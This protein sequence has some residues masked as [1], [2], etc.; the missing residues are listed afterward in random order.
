MV[1][2]TSSGHRQ[3]GI[4][5]VRTPWSRRHFLGAAG[6]G[7]ASLLV[8]TSLWL[9]QRETSSVPNSFTG[10]NP[11]RL[12]MHVH[13]SWSEQTGSWEA[14][15]AQA[16]A[17]GT[18]VL[19]MT[20]HDYRA[21]ASGYFS[22]LNG[23]TWVRATT[24]GLAQ[25]TSTASGGS[26]H[27]LAESSSATTSASVTMSVRPKPDAVNRLRTSVAGQTLVQTATSARLTQGAS[28]EV[29]VSMSYHPAASGR[30]AGT[31][32]LVYR[33]GG[34]TGQRFTENGGL[35][36]V[37]ALPTPAAGSVRRLSPETDITALWPTMLPI[38]N[39]MYGL[40]FR[41]K[42]P[43][44]GA[45]ADITVAGLKFERTQNSAAS[46]TANQSRLIS[47]YQSRFPN[48]TVRAS[49][50]IGRSMLHM[51]PFGIPQY[52]PN[53]AALPTDENT[54]F[55]QV[56]S[57]VH[58]QHGAVSWNHPFGYDMGPLLSQAD[59]I[60]KRRSIFQSMLALGELGV[61]ILEVGYKIRGY[62]DA[63][64][65]IALWDTFSRNGTFLTANGTTDDHSG[66]PW[67]NLTNGF[68]TGAWAAS[69]SDAD[70]VAALVAG[71]AYVTDMKRW[72][73]GE[74]DLLVDG[75]V[76]MGAVSVSSRVSR[77]LSIW[78]RSLPANCGVQVLS[79]PV[80]YKGAVDPGTVVVRTLTPS[81]FAGGK[82][83]LTVDTSTSRFYRIQVVGSDG[84]IIG[85]SNPVWLLREVPPGGIPPA[86]IVT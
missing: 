15:F 37:V 41:A 81:A 13:G 67:T 50:E 43:R 59:R 18:D 78:T 34:G 56:V 70:V 74:A 39:A 35:T 66:Q 36:G 9:P 2:A 45:V 71:R 28:Y 21:T 3:P 6:A 8:P 22:S 62:V 23:V 76:R 84:S 19:F 57:A 30:P 68:T 63:A 20:D 1:D 82:A 52:W 65:H 24:G 86:R 58:A 54:R 55:R 79:G 75:S 60:T 69:R 51:N 12:A 5:E 11:L 27:L 61:D 40:S 77:T 4:S 49:S 14:Q 17:T 46:V 64:T 83:T 42:S 33:F 10:A 25:Q 53:Y 73:G 80:D 85:C 31:Y 72:P 29:V 7:A 47:T 48:L 44:R 16:V 32:E 26:L 38:D